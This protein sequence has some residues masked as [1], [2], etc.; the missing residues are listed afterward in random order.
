MLRTHLGTFFIAN[1]AAACCCA[2]AG[3]TKALFLG[4]L[5]AGETTKLA[6]VRRPRRPAA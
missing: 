6:G 2:V 5:T 1:L 4:K 3:A